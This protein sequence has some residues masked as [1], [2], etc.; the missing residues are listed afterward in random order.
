M[1]KVV[2]D[3]DKDL[4]STVFLSVCFSTTVEIF[5]HNRRWCISID[6]KFPPLPL[7]YPLKWASHEDA[8]TG[9]L[10]KLS[11]CVKPI[12]ANHHVLICQVWQ[13]RKTLLHFS[14]GMLVP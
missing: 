12:F 9:H 5:V 6:G 2:D 11:N 8:Y 1:S 4:I 3:L 7:I 13:S 14:F 10:S